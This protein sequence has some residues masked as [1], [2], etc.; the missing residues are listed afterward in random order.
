M[1]L[2]TS[3]SGD[4]NLY[5]RLRTGNGSATLISLQFITLDHYSGTADSLA[6][7]KIWYQFPVGDR[8]TAWVGPKNRKLLYECST[9]LS[10]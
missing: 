9:S 4:D 3:F 7:D 5:V 2:N 10:L 6:V 8:I 1:D